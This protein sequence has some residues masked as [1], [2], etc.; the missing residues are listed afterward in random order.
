MC[1]NRLPRPQ[2]WARSRELHDSA[3]RG[4]HT[5]RATTARVT[6]PARAVHSARPAINAQ[7]DPARSSLPQAGV[8]GLT[9]SSNTIGAL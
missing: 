4:R 3:C 5:P 6:A 2:P 7:P 9:S 8:V 1:P